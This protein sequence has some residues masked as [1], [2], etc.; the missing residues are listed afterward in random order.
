MNHESF[1]FTANLSEDDKQENDIEKYLAEVEYND[2]TSN[3][4][5]LRRRIAMAFTSKLAYQLLTQAKFDYNKQKQ[6]MIGIL[7]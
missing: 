7:L 4:S 1:R 3:P 5:R 2:D 6:N